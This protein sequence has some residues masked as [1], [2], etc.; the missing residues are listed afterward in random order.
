MNTQTVGRLIGT[1]K[2][3]IFVLSMLCL[4]FLAAST[5]AQA[6][7]PW[8]RAVGEAQCLRDVTE[9][10][11]NRAHRLFPSCPAT[12]FACALDESACRLREMVKCGADLG[13]IQAELNRFKEIQSLLCR[14]VSADFHVARDR[15]IQNYLRVIDDRYG[16]LVRDLAKCK[17]PVPDC[18]NPYPSHYHPPYPVPYSSSFGSYPRTPQ[19]VQPYSSFQNELYPR[20]MNPNVGPNIPQ[21]WQGSIPSNLNNPQSTYDFE[22]QL[23][24]NSAGTPRSTSTTLPQEHPIAAEILSMILTNARR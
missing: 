2:T 18:R 3:T 19:P 17:P 7:N 6:S 24:G 14:A 22:L 21:Y 11:S 23:P 10:L 1:R 9:D 13:S 20:N 4:I 5:P 8:G 16:D 15:S 12:E